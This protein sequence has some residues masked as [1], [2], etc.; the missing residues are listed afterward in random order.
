MLFYRTNIQ[1]MSLIQKII[2]LFKDQGT[3][4]ETGMKY[5][6]VGLGNI[7][8]KYENTRHNIGFKVVDALAAKFEVP[9]KTDK[10]G[11]VAQFRH[12]GRVFVLLKP[13]TYMNLSGKSVRHWMQK[14]KV[15]KSNILVIVDDLNLDFGSIRLRGKGNHGGHNGL[16]DIDQM[17][18]GN[19]YARLRLGVGNSFSKGKQVDYVLGEWTKEESAQLS[20]IITKA[21]DAALSYG[22]IGLAHTMNKFNKS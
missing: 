21:G 16:K 3:E 11:D 20:D 15:D 9:F 4:E 10:L 7:G 18:G 1:F 22:T 19:N 14:T 5:L 12:K 8:A 2:Q 6:I 13:S 17:T